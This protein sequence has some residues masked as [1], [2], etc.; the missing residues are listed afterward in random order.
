[1]SHRKRILI[2]DDEPN[3]IELLKMRLEADGYDVI[4]AANG[5]EGLEKIGSSKVDL[6]L[7]DVVMAD[8]DGYTFLHKIRASVDTRV[9][10]IIVITGKPGM[11]EIFSIEGVQ[12]VLDK[13]FEDKELMFHVREVLG[14]NRE[15]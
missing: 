9:I 3:F 15:R 4:A 6:I 11:K 2:V 1:M 5:K 14:D 13:P 10:P 7:L 12:A 8:M